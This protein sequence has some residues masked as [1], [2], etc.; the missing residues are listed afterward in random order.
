MNATPPFIAFTRNEPSAAV[1]ASSQRMLF[2]D[3]KSTRLN[4]SHQIIS[5]AVFCL[6]KKCAASIRLGY[7]PYCQRARQAGPGV[8]GDHRRPTM[9]GC[10]RKRVSGRHPGLPE[11]AQ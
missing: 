7:E 10:A 11:D 3:R 8:G 5:Y 4:S 2:R 9:R 6:K 1:L